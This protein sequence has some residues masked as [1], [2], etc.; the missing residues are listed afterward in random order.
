[1][2]SFSN[3]RAR[4]EGRMYQVHSNGEVSS[5][6]FGF[7]SVDFAK[8]EC[9]QWLLQRPDLVF[10]SVMCGGVLVAKAGEFP[11]YDLRVSLAS[12]GI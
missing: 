12:I 3:F 4:Y 9:R 1:M 2:A 10:V 5:F 11:W 8:S 6:A 7:D